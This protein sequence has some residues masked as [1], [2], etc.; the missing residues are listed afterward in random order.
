MFWKMGVLEILKRNKIT[1][2]LG[3]PVGGGGAFFWEGGRLPAGGGGWGGGG[4]GVG[5][6]FFW[7]VA[8]F[9]P[10]VLLENGLLCSFNI[11]F[12]PGVQL[13]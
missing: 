12:I 1:Q 7:K 3:M 9:Q 4:G 6:L 8:G 11:V 13:V 5:R 10:V 2:G